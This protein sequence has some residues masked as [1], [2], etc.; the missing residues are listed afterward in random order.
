[1]SIFEA[2]IRKGIPVSED[3]LTSKVFGTLRIVENGVLERL[4]AGVF[5]IER[6]L[7]QD[8]DLKL[9]EKYRT[10]KPDE[11]I[12]K[13]WREPDVSITNRNRGLG[14]F[15]E[16]KKDREL[17][18]TQLIDEYLICSQWFSRP[19]LLVVTCDYKDRHM[20]PR[21][22]RDA[23][24]PEDRIKHITWKDINRFLADSCDVLEDGLKKSLLTDVIRLL[25]DL[26][27]RGV[28]GLEREKIESLGDDLENVR[29]FLKEVEVFADDLEEQ[30][31]GTDVIFLE[32]TARKVYRDG[33]SHDWSSEKWT[34]S[35][36]IYA[37]GEEDWNNRS[38]YDLE[39]GSYI[40][41][42]FFLDWKYFYV[43]YWGNSEETKIPE[44]KLEDLEL[45]ELPNAYLYE[46]GI[47]WQ[48]KEARETAELLDQAFIDKLKGLEEEKTGFD[49]L[50]SFP[51]DSLSKDSIQQTLQT[52]AERL[53]ILN[54][55]LKKLGL[56]EN[57]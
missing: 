18:V 34:P 33:T 22:F 56:R 17:N 1:M 31:E 46:R 7:L 45:Q 41:L 35:Y 19:Y 23:D 9:W 40:Y 13:E 49:I 44:L 28:R 29:D 47:G 16:A 32:G 27:Y 30:L 11:R 53:Q 48:D 20:V 8:F 12:A 10:R 55:L 51:I 5:G 37:L 52:C 24:I 57:A 42:A 54:G 26:G 36:I 25:N 15:V 2:E 14:V 21:I 3:S 43:G 4:L 38:N 6:N 39:S 50:F